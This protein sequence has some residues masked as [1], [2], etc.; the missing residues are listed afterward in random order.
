[1]RRKRKPYFPPQEDAPPPLTAVVRRRV[2]FEEVDPLAIVWHGRYPSY[3]EDGRAA[4]GERYD[5]GYATMR[6]ENFLAP[7]VQMHIDYH[8][9]LRFR[10][11]MTITTRLHWSDAARLNF[12]Y[13][14]EGES[15]ITAATAYTV[16]LFTNLEKEIL[17]ARPPYMELFCERWRS[18]ELS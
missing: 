3:M 8:S 15:G 1:M 7:I 10:E 14:I 18:G 13:L 17:L 11:E 16:Q 12:D 2:R 5:L 6:R 4:F 9:P